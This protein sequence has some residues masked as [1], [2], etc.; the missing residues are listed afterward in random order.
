MY[1]KLNFMQ[2]ESLKALIF[3]STGAVG[4]VNYTITK[5]LV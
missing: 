4:S 1:Q 2:K 5:E 3:G